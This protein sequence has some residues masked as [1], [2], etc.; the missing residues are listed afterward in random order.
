MSG[1]AAPPLS[2]PSSP[3]LNSWAHAREHFL[4][5][6]VTPVQTFHWLLWDWQVTNEEVLGKEPS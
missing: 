1:E 4:F 3:A 5:V 2:G 6:T